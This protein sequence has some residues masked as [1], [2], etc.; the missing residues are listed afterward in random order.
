MSECCVCY[1]REHPVYFYANALQY[2]FVVI[3]LSTPRIL[4]SGLL[5]CL[6]FNCTCSS[7]YKTG[8]MSTCHSLS[9]LHMHCPRLPIIKFSPVA[10]R[11]CRLYLRMPGRIEGVS[12]RTVIIFYRVIHLKPYS[13]RK[14]FYWSVLN[15]NH[16]S[17]HW[18]ME[19]IRSMFWRLRGLV[20]RCSEWPAHW[21]LNIWACVYRPE[22]DIQELL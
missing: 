20:H 19:D 5:I 2:F 16:M 3:L 13:S 21:P 12:T 6:L 1:R 4:C 9:D 10:L 7:V 11:I 15:M 8:N 22:C 17:V 14:V 18:T